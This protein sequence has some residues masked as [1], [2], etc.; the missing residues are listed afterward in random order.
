MSPSDFSTVEVVARRS[1]PAA[2]NASIPTTAFIETDPT[3]YAPHIS[4][5]SPAPFVM[6]S[7]LATTRAA[8]GGFDKQYKID[9]DLN[10]ELAKAAKDAGTKAYVLISSQGAST[11][12]F[13]AYPKMKGEIEEHVKDMNFEHT[14]ILRPGLISC[15]REGRGVF[16]AVLCKVAAGMGKVNTHWLKDGWAQDPDVI[17]RAAVAAAL[18]AQNGEVKDKVWVMGQS[19]IIRLGRSEW[20]H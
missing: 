3:K 2:Q 20:Q 1:P 10:V 13:F 11:K 12:S 4:S 8:A 5:L 14:I 6:F 17:A 16:E 9:H 18:K 15:E 19:D 7:A